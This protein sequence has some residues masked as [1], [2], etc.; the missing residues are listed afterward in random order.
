[1]RYLIAYLIMPIGMVR[2]A[3]GGGESVVRTW[4]VEE[5]SY[6]AKGV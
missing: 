1:M 5:T 2:Y 4:R 3:C 6:A